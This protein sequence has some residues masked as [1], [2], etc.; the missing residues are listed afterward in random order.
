MG[1][2]LLNLLLN[3]IFLPLRLFTFLI[4]FVKCRLGLALLC[5]IILLSLN[6]N[7]LLLLDL[8]ATVV[9]EEVS[10][11]QGMLVSLTL[12][13]SLIFSAPDFHT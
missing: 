4:G 11:V 2:Q 13:L 6:Q 7:L 12:L 9:N 5:L 8:I 1:D 3:L 10:L